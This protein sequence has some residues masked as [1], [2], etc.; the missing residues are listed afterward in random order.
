MFRPAGGNAHPMSVLWWLPTVIK[1]LATG[2]LVVAASVAAEALGPL[3]GAVIASLPVSAGPAYVFLSM[4]HGADY[5]AA[6][7]LSSVAANAAIGVFLMVYGV[8]AARMPAWR[9]LGISVAVW[10]AAALT[11]LQVEWTAWSALALNLAVYGAGFVVLRATRP[12]Q[13]ASAP[14]LRRG[15]FELLIRAAAVAGLVTVVVAA[16]GRLGPAATGILAVFPVSLI[17][18]FVVVRPRIGGAAAALLAAHALRAML[19]FGLMLLALHLAIGPWGVPAALVT[20]LAVS[21]AW[22]A[23]LLV[24]R[25]KSA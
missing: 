23:A 1:A 4:Q 18:L 5:L 15:R 9:S 20:A 14:A 21:L 3:W 16:S 13:P 19:G 11:T 12:A 17:S 24:L 22:S 25:R 6:S 7:A 8:L 2:L 10:L